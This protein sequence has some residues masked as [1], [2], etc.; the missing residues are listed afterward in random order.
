MP[1]QNRPQLQRCNLRLTTAS[2]NNLKVY[3]KCICDFRIGDPDFAQE[4]VVAKL[5]GLRGIIGVDFLTKHQ[6]EI[7][8]GE[9]VLRLGKYRCDLQ[10]VVATASTCAR[11]R[12]S[13]PISIPENTECYFPG[14]IDGNIS[15]EEGIVEPVEKFSSEGLLLA[16]MLVR[17]RKG[18]QITLSVLNLSSRPVKLQ[19]NTHI[20]TVESVEHVYQVDEA[21]IESNEL[22]PLSEG[23]SVQL[24][25]NEKTEVR[26]LLVEYQDIF[27][28]PDGKL[29]RTDL[30]EH[31][32]DTGQAEPIKIPARRKKCLR[33]SLIKCWKVG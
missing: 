2:G 14:Y 30:G 5:E 7:S 31:H 16:R 21:E 13:E 25:E 11:I 27:A 4:V 24:R 20:A 22:E 28:G 19:E 10:P 15:G 8:F 1:A 6:G 33:M 23:L 18:K 9:K 32:I 3:G 17:P 26:Q 12:V 29:G